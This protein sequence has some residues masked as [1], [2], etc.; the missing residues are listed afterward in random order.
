MRK[1]LLKSLL[2]LSIIS[3]TL[4]TIVPTAVDAMKTQQESDVTDNKHEKIEELRDELQE[5]NLDENMSDEK[6]YK[7]L[8]EQLS[9]L[10]LKYEEFNYQE[11]VN[12]RLSTLQA[13]L[14]DIKKEIN[15]STDDK[16]KTDIEY[17]YKKLDKIY[18]NDWNNLVCFVK[19]EYIEKLSDKVKKMWID[20]ETSEDIWIDV[21]L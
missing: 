15:R 7:E 13:S 8:S 6:E 9:D 20:E 2:L 21:S 19:S 18:N 10:E 3:G 4:I 11:E 1:K 5:F 17:R 16:K 14:E 12:L